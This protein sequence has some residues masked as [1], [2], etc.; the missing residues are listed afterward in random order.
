MVARKPRW[1][2]D[3]RAV[4]VGA[5]SAFSPALDTLRTLIDEAGW[6]AEEPEVHLLPHL[7]SASRPMV[8][9]SPSRE[10]RLN[11]TGCSS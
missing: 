5:A 1:D 10:R 3:E 4:G 7:E 2:N 8:P 11:R 9:A 6:V